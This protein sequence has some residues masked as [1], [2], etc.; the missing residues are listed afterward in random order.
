MQSLP[1]RLEY[2]FYVMGA[3]NLND[4]LHHT[5]SEQLQSGWQSNPA[6]KTL[7]NDYANYHAVLVAAG[8][9]LVLIFVLLSIFFWIRLKRTPLA[10]KHTWAFEKKVYCSFGLLSLLVGLFLALIVAVNATNV[11]DPLH[12]F[13]LL[14]GSLATPNTSVVG[15]V[16]NEWIKSGNGNIPPLIE[17]KIHER[18]AWQRPK[19][20]VCGMLLVV[21]VA[22]SA[23]LWNTLLKKTRAS[24]SKWRLK[25]ITCFVAGIA[26]VTLSF[27]MAVM[28]VANMQ[29]AIAPI[30]ITVLGANG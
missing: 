3:I 20:M 27:L 23:L 2:N 6:M 4:E 30:T 8:G 18:I 7:I 17:Q 15:H 9:C 25:E 22:L 21:F 28:V 13:S 1:V 11:F 29:G 14:V 26:S 19:A 12:G 5:L 10:V 24:E 16:L